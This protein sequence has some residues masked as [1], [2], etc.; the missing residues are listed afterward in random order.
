MNVLSTA[1]PDVKIIEPSVFG[2][3]RGFF[4]ESWNQSAFQAADLPTQFVQDN[5]SRS[6]RGTLRGL[7]Y[8]FQRPQGKLVR[9]VSGCVFD[10]AVD[11]R[12]SSPHFGQSVAVELSAENHRML[13]IP[14]GFAHGFLVLSET[15]DFVYKCTDYYF[16][17]YERSL[18]WN[19]A[20]LQIRW[21]IALGE[22]P[23]LSAKDK[24]G[25]P[26]S[27]CSTFA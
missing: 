14:P 22:Q 15:A 9:V 4:L 21:P 7:H 25:L 23:L 17:D 19:D 10:V 6:Q 20:T 24:A 16:P 1:N 13:W 27:E 18:I 2:D 11:L 8:Q 12:R 26:L 5:H 3:H